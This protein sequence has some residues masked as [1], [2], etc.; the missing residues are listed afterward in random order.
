MLQSLSSQFQSLPVDSPRSSLYSPNPNGAGDECNLSVYE[1]PFR[2]EEEEEAE[3]EA[4]AAEEEE[5]EDEEV[6]EVRNVNGVKIKIQLD[7]QKKKGNY[8]FDSRSGLWW[9][10]SQKMFYNPTTK[11]YYMTP[12]GKPYSFDRSNNRMVLV[13]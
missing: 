5:E 4:D 1:D 9:H 2:K 11:N 3:A 8:I 13:G 10:P 7:H 12:R 6:E